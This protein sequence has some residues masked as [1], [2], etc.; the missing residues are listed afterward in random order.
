MKMKTFSKIMAVALTAMMTLSLTACEDESVPAY[1]TG[2]ESEAESSVRYNLSPTAP[3]ETEPTA[4]VE[5][6]IYSAR[7]DYSDLI[8]DYAVLT[9]LVTNNTNVPKKASELIYVTVTDNQGRD[10]IF[11]PDWFSD[12]GEG[13]Y[14]IVDGNTQVY[15]MYAYGLQSLDIEYIDIVVHEHP[16]ENG[17]SYTETNVLDSQRFYLTEE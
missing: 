1:G 9:L 10:E 15:V 16:G 6:Y 4:P 7:I 13:I 2:V 11:Y 14:R 3:I 12:S 5:A 8:G 17:D